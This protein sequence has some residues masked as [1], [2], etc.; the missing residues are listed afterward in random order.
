MSDASSREPRHFPLGGTFEVKLTFA[1][2]LTPGTFPRAF[3]RGP[4]TL[5]REYQRELP[6]AATIS[7][8]HEQGT[9]F[10][11]GQIARDTEPGL[12]DLER[13]D[14]LHSV[15]GINDAKKVTTLH[16]KDL[17]PFA[18]IVDPISS[19]PIPQVPPITKI[20]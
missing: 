17:A 16:A 11:Q 1:A 4:N 7:P 3:L 19:R 12:Y 2:P 10:L 18:I 20:E 14:I 9:Y 5:E 13:V 6:T 8:K 15:T